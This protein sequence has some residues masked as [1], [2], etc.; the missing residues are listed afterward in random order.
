MR[1]EFGGAFSGSRVLVTG[2]TGF[3]G[4]WLSRWLLD[5]G[6]ELTGYALEPDTTPALFTDLGLA[7][8]M[9]S[10]IGDIRDAE[11]VAALI[12]EVRPDVVLHLA[13]QPLV[14]R[15]YAEPRYT[16]EVNVLGT[17]N[18]LE[19]VRSS[20]SCR[21]LVNV[22][23]DKVYANA[24]TGEAFA[25]D[26][27]LGGHDP[28]SASKA[29]SEIVTASYRDSFFSGPDTAA[30]ATA[31][32]GNVIG[33]GD[34][35]E[36]RLVPDCARAL[37]AGR[38]LVVRNP[39]SVRPWQHVLEPLSGYLHLAASLL[40][41]GA[42]A[43]PYN[44]GPD[45]LAAR[46][47]GE[48]ADRFVAAWGE[49]SWESPDLGAQ[50]HEAAQ[51]QLD[52]GKAERVLGWRPVWAFDDTIQRTAVWYHAYTGGEDAIA[53][54]EADFDAYLSAAQHTAAPWV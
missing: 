54:V 47:V 1:R 37:S 33:G 39:D 13:A 50:P 53:L 4:A 32:A 16:F 34:W 10:R 40:G 17:V 49:G 25:E 24:E 19:A 26:R 7:A 41:D 51:L 45:P 8:A 22:T 9:D 11:R 38:P 6:A 43:G 18:M 21:V 36:D 27:P 52:I 46:T 23:T 42:L 48:V 30:I 44:F 14:R 20:E 35:A 3:K 31:R 15:S 28:Y 29:G 2:H 5:L 12:A